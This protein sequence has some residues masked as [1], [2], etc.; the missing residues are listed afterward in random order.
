MQLNGAVTLLRDYSL[1]KIDKK[2]A[3]EKCALL[4][5]HKLISGG[6]ENKGYD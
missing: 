2:R 6:D 1:I 3:G 4:N 5:I